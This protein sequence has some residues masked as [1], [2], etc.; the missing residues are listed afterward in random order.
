M[1]MQ[2][3]PYYT[4]VPTDLIRTIVVIAECGSLSKAA[5]KLGLSQP[6]LSAHVKRAES[7]LRG[8]IFLKSANGTVLTE[9]GQLVL[10][11]ARRML[12]A[13]DQI[14]RIGGATDGPQPLR[15]GISTPF[16]KDFFACRK[17]D[18]LRGIVVTADASINIAKALSD[19]HLDIGCFYE[20]TD[21][22][23]LLSNVQ[24]VREA[25]EKFVWVRSRDFVIRPGAPIPILHSPKFDYL[26]RVMTANEISYRVVF[27]TPDY[28][29]RVAAAHSGAGLTALPLRMLPSS[30]VQAKEYYLPE[31]PPVKR[32]LCSRAN[33]NSPGA[34][35]II[36]ELAR[37]FFDSAEDAQQPQ[38]AG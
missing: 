1:P 33:L 2:E 7:L 12:D 23:A 30:L 15:I 38:K 9:L 26:M 36:D 34:S 28:E 37:T 20:D 13:N 6:A 24:L 3:R 25:A 18:S 8:E 31:L 32:L 10:A 21:V 11:Q 4:N 27:S 5:Q 29:A 14:L 16:V 17:S 22:T 35:K 19:G